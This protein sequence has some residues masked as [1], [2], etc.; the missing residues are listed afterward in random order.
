MY[1]SCRYTFF[2]SFGFSGDRTNFY[3]PKSSSFP[4]PRCQSRVPRYRAPPPPSFA[5]T[6]NLTHCGQQLGSL[7]LALCCS[8]IIRCGSQLTCRLLCVCRRPSLLSP[9]ASG[10]HPCSPCRGTWRRIAR[11][12]IWPCCTACRP[13]RSQWSRT[14]STPSGWTWRRTSSLAHGFW[15]LSSSSVVR[16]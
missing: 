7:S 13:R 1:A 5:Q 12:I 4:L 15:C 3:R 10:T 2:K 6:C 14:A 16:R 8:S 11:S 9:T